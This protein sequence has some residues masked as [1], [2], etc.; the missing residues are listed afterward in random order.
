MIRDKIKNEQYFDNFITQL[1]RSQEK[2]YEK[3]NEKKIKQDRLPIVKHDMSIN[4]LRLIVAKYSRGD[5][6]FSNEILTD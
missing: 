3:F 6:M 2:R 1:Y 4:Y 5:N